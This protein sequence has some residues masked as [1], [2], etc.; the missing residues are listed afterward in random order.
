MNTVAVLRFRM[1]KILA[2]DSDDRWQ[3]YEILK[4]KQLRDNYKKETVMQRK[5]LLKM[6]EVDMQSTA[7]VLF[8]EMFPQVAQK[9]D[10]KSFVLLIN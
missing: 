8:Q 7:C 3:Q 9:N 4:C 2:Y 5:N 10:K 6:C 1:A